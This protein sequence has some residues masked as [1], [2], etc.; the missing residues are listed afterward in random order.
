VDKNFPRLGK[1][2]PRHL[3]D[4]QVRHDL[5]CLKKVWMLLAREG[6]LYMHPTLGANQSNVIDFQVVLVEAVLN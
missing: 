2:F 4:L 6:T 5:A 3:L 1:K